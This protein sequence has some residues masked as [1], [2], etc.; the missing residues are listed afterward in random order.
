MNKSNN[1]ERTIIKLHFEIGYS[2]RLGKVS[3]NSKLSQNQVG[4]HFFLQAIVEEAARVRIIKNSRL[5]YEKFFYEVAEGI[6]KEVT[7]VTL[8]MD[9]SNV[10]SYSDHLRSTIFNQLRPKLHSSAPYEIFAR[11]TSNFLPPRKRSTFSA[12][13]KRSVSF[14]VGENSD[15]RDSKG[16]QSAFRRTSRGC[17]LS[18]SVTVIEPGWQDWL[19][20]LCICRNAWQSFEPRLA[21]NRLSFHSICSFI[22]SFRPVAWRTP[23]GNIQDFEGDPATP[24]KNYFI[25]LESDRERPDP[26]F[27]LVDIFNE[28]LSGRVSGS[29]EGLASCIGNAALVIARQ[30]QGYRVNGEIQ[31]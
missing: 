20:A 30:Y 6:R 2:P 27:V 8:P 28:S 17:S 15:L 31:G 29:L 25:Q 3:V 23:I 24:E 19:D 1:N 4:V 16:F 22:Y 18:R 7:R 5:S 21:V 26:S 13:Q 10:K 14:G 12:L 9:E 11:I